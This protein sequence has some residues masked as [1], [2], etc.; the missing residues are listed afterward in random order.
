MISELAK[1]RLTEPPLYFSR[2]LSAGVVAKRRAGGPS[3]R[4]R[5]SGWQA[6]QA[7][8]HQPRQCVRRTGLTLPNP[9]QPTTSREI[10]PNSGRSTRARRGRHEHVMS[11]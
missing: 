8:V 11:E 5:D 2:R 9:Q 7:H 1:V 3:A 10:A 6:S 4:P